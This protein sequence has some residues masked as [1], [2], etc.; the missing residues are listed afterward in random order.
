[1]LKAMNQRERY[2]YVSVNVN[3]S[4]VMRNFKFKLCLGLTL[5]LVS[6]PAFAKGSDGSAGFL[7]L[8][9]LGIVY[10]IFQSVVK[11]RV[12]QLCINKR[13]TIAHKVIN[14]FIIFLNKKATLNEWL[15]L[16]LFF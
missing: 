5:G 16:N 1:L 11:A 4:S 3:G 15:V 2:S 7:I 6:A 10:W 12:E 9:V 14:R 13:Q 8:I